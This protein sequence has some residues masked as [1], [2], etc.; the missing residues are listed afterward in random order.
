MALSKEITLT[1][2]D[3]S[4]TLSSAIKFYV[5]DCVDLIF[6]LNRW[7]ID[8]D[9]GVKEANPFDLAGITADLL[10]EN[11]GL[12]DTIEPTT[13]NQNRIV[14]RF[15]NKYTRLEG[16]GRMQLRLRD[17]DEYELKLPPFSYEIQKSINEMLDDR[18]EVTLATEDGMALLTEDGNMLNLVKISNLPE[19]SKIE[20]SDYMIVNNDNV[21]KKVLV[22]E[23]K[24]SEER[25]EQMDSIPSMK[26]DIDHISSELSNHTHRYDDLIDKPSV[27]DGEDGATF[28]PHVGDNGELSWTNDK[29]LPNPVTVNIKGPQGEKGDQGPQGE[30]GND[31]YTPVK[32]V[33][34]FDGEKG[35]QGPQGEKGNDGYTPVK[36]VDYFDGEKGDQGP[37]GEKGKDGLTTSVSVNGN[38]YDHAN[39]T[40]TLPDYPSVPTKV[41]ELTND[42]KY[43]TEV[44][45]NDALDAKSDI[46]HTH[47]E[48]D[49]NKLVL[50]TVNENSVLMTTDRNQYISVNNNIRI[51]LPSIT[52]YQRV[53]ELHLYVVAESSL[54]EI[55]IEPSDYTAIKWQNT[56]TFEV[57]CI[58]ELIFT[59]INGS[60]LAGCVVYKE[61]S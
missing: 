29:E 25:L 52:N 5:N 30:K 55:S 11:P 44:K 26:D 58:N 43:V 31:G 39:G 20:Y 24:C 49:D 38:V 27:I 40:I 3:Y 60:W 50:P 9:N 35:D 53:F 61:Q 46:D 16:I 51:I 8:N 2:K 42:S 1:I 48:Y 7:G 10:V 4:I 47:E 54:L 56:P 32:G 15:T 14:F 23:I 18:N 22:S 28:T 33:D 57:D 36:G 45:M 17:D 13:I 6:I 41:S 37:Q 19:A 59:F 34:Y 21:T 12:N